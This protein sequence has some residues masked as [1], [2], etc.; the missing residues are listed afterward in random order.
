MF[1]PMTPKI[2][3]RAF[4]TKKIGLIFTAGD[5]LVEELPPGMPKPQG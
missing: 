3:E 4:N 2:D 1:D 5:V